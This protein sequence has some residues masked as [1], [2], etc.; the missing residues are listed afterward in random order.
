[1]SPGKPA[2][3][4]ALVDVDVLQVHVH[5]DDATAKDRR[6]E[7][8]GFKEAM[9]ELKGLI[10]HLLSKPLS[11]GEVENEESMGKDVHS[12]KIRPEI[13]CGKASYRRMRRPRP[14]VGEENEKKEHKEAEKGLRKRGKVERRE[15]T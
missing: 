11:S 13:G 6:R 9:K 2:A 8:D 12:V 3:G 7:T 14:R 15:K 1:M 10:I 4:G 5:A